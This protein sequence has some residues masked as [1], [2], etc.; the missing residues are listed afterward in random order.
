MWNCFSMVKLLFIVERF[1]VVSFCKLHYIG[2]VCG[3]GYAYHNGA[4]VD[5]NAPADDE[6]EC[7]H[8]CNILPACEFWDFGNGFC[9]LRSDEG[10]G[11]MNATSFAYGPKNCYFGTNI[12]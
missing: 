4:I 2:L 12:S 9:R 7:L 11:P 6:T 1:I 10:S 8:Q 3:F 5:G